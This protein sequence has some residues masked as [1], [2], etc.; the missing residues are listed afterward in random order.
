MIGC[1]SCN[2]WESIFVVQPACFFQ[3]FHFLRFVSEILTMSF[4]RRSKFSRRSRSAANALFET[5]K[6]W[7]IGLF[8]SLYQPS[9]YGAMGKFQILDAKRPSLM[10]AIWISQVLESG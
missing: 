2:H 4:S 10:F 3:L 1:V 5:H 9:F 7:N 6:N 8:C